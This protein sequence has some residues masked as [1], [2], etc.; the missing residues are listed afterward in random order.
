MRK[1]KRLLSF[2]LATL[3]LLSSPG[4]LAKDNVSF[5]DIKSTDW[6]YGSVINLANKGIIGGYSDNTFRP[7]NSVTVAEFIKL[8]LDVAG[9]KSDYTTSPWHKD[10]MQKALDYG[11]IDKNLYQTPDTSIKR[12]DVALILSKLIEKTPG[13]KGEFV[14][15]RSKEYDRFKYL[16]YDTTKLSQEY[17]DAVYKLFEYGLIVGTTNK[18][19]QV[20]YSPEDKLTRAEIVAIVERLIEPSKRLDKYA[21]Y[22]NRD[23]V[24]NHESLGDMFSTSIATPDIENKRLILREEEFFSQYENKLY[25][26]VNNY[27]LSEKLN[28]HIN[29]Q[30]YDLSKAMITESRFVET[31]LMGTLNIKDDPFKSRVYVQYATSQKGAY[32]NANY[33]TYMF[34]EK[35]PYNAK[36]DSQISKMSDKVVIGVDLGRLFSAGLN[37]TPT[38]YT[39]LNGMLEYEYANK[40]RTSLIAIFGEKDG[41][42][43]YE[44]MLGEYIADR[45]NPNKLRTHDHTQWTYKTKTIG[46]YKIEYLHGEKAT[47]SF[48][49]SFIE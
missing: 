9:I 48:K 39:E 17:R 34:Y 21:E 14:T 41:H 38:S 43:I 4:V 10:L 42:E 44:Y 35:E 5:K 27:I 49:I 31:R 36:E 47:L 6:Y 29:Q 16:L 1:S 15:E 23:N 32:Y 46:K 13:L 30:I 7:N 8:S 45:S 11:L 40:F 25:P 12:K 22:P 20:F 18:K 19:D 37:Y 24:F 33:W 3:I 2:I 28:P 26:E